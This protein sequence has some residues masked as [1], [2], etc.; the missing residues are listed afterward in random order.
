MHFESQSEGVDGVNERL[1]RWRLWRLFTGCGVHADR[2]F[3]QFL[4]A[5]FD[6]FGFLRGGFVR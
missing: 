2:E 1:D 6:V 5:T 3:G 4:V